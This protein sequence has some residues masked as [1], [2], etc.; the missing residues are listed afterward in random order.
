MT[1][2]QRQHQIIRAFARHYGRQWRRRIR[3]VWTTGNLPIDSPVADLDVAAELLALQSN[4]ESW[5]QDFA[6]SGINPTRPRLNDSAPN[7]S[8]AP[9]LLLAIADLVLMAEAA[10]RV[11]RTLRAD[12]EYQHIAWRRASQAIAD[13]ARFGH[14]ANIDIAEIVLRLESELDEI[15]A[16][17]Q[18]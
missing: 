5:L 8:E 1:I 13:L 2:S 12:T 10:V 16:E 9:T 18:S 6:P 14:H 7:L 15:P 4:G 11:S 17:V 3:T